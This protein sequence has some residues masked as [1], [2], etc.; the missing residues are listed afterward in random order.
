MD[1]LQGAKW[2]TKFDVREGFYQIRIK[3]GHEW[4][5]AFK[6]KYGL[7][8]YTVMPFGLTNAPA[9]FQLVINNALHEYLG[10]FVTAYLDDVLVYSSGTLE[11]H[12]EHV[13]KVLRKLKEY[14]LY[15]QPGKCE[16]HVK[17]TEFLGFI[18]STEGVKM[19]PKKIATVQ[20]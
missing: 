10:I 7:F 2:F 4:M 8:E 5:T 18:V 1:R 6:T 14:K 3:E 19:N 15:L 12:V 20:E 16:F 13:K 11:E 9:T 17:E